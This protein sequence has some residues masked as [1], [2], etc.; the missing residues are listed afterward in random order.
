MFSF[1]SNKKR[2]ALEKYVRRLA[3]TTTP[4]IHPI[5]EDT[6]VTRRQNRVLPTILVPWE[7]GELLVDESATVLIK[8]I[9][10]HGVGLVLNQPFR[11]MEVL[12]CLWLA[13]EES[14]WFFRGTVRQNSAIGGGFWVLGIELTDF[15]NANEISKVE[16]LLSLVNK[17]LPTERPGRASELLCP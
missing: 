17:L 4:N 10:D 15:L 12:I 11:A 1:K 7:D 8:D 16:E 2:L 13:D 9:S 14:P 3:D 5:A 6:R